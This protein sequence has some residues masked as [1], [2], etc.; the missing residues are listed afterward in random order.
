MQLLL[1]KQ[2]IGV[3]TQFPV[4]GS[5]AAVEHL[6]VG[7][8]VTFVKT[9]PVTL[10]HVSRVQLL[11]SLQVMNVLLQP[12]TGS[13]ESVVHVLLSSQNEAGRDSK[14]QKR[15]G[16]EVIVLLQRLGSLLLSQSVGVS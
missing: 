2:T 5:Q 15:K 7:L 11:S 1:S 9:H 13:Q 16:F 10:S 4:A 6:S 12:V 3:L 8:H 14:S